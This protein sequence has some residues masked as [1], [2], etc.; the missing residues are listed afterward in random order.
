MKRLISLDDYDI[1]LL[2]TRKPAFNKLL[3]VL[4]TI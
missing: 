1:L 2:H 3:L 4:T